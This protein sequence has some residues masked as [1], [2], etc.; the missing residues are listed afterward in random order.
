MNRIGAS[1]LAASALM[2]ATVSPGLAQNS[3]APNLSQATKAA[4]APAGTVTG[5][6]EAPPL[7][8]IGDVPVHLWAPVQPP[9]DSRMNR[10]PAAEPFWEAGMPT[11]QSGF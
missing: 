8:K 2:L 5:V 1:I 9:Y 11:T 7:F 10:D 3:V 4:P 6:R